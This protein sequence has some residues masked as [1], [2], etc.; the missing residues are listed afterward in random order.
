MSEKKDA[1][2]VVRP[3]CRHL[4]SKGMYV[5]GTMDP[6]T[7]DYEM[8][9]GYCWCALSQDQLGPDDKIVDRA[10]CKPGRACYEPPV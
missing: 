5:S 2:N 4:L 6:E 10:D 1:L 8:G 9:D 7:D 3:A